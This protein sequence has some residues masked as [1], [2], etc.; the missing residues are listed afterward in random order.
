MINTIFLIAVP[1]KMSASSS[2]IE[3]QVSCTRSD[4]GETWSPWESDGG[5]A[6]VTSNQ[7]GSS[8]GVKVIAPGNHVEY[9]IGTIRGDYNEMWSSLASDG[10]VANVP[11]NMTPT[12]LMI[13]ITA[14]SCDVEY[15]IGTIRGDYLEYWSPWVSNGEVAQ[16]TSNMTPMTFSLKAILEAPPPTNIDIDPDTLNLKSKGRWITCYIDI[17]GYD[18]NEIDI[19]TILLEDTIP[20]EWGDVQ[21]TILMVKFDRGE[22]EDYIGSP[23]ESIE[24]WVTGKFYDGAEFEGS[25]TIRVIC[26]P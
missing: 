4:T 17:P 22:V 10:G 26:P 2:K 15:Q 12:T 23:Q 7:L 20:A 6:T 16:I 13:K 19:S 9:Q 21:G 18:V 24:L 14:P 5:V 8:F 1:T 3:Y 11:T 25:D